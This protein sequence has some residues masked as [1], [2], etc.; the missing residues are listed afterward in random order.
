M[1][2]ARLLAVK[3][4]QVRIIYGTGHPTVGGGSGRSDACR[5]CE[6]MN[7]DDKNPFSNAVPSYKR[8]YSHGVGRPIHTL[9]LCVGTSPAA[10]ARETIEAPPA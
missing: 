3:F 10:L 9:S 4:G 7:S 1:E 2:G 6:L 8:I 5:S